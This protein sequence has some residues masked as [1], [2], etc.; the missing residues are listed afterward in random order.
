MNIAAAP[1]SDAAALLA[2]VAERVRSA[3]AARDLPRRAL[4]EMS[5]VS[6]RYLAQLEAGEGNISIALLNRV[7]DALG[8]P[9]DA[10]IAE[11]PPLPAD[12]MR[13][14]QLYNAAP[15]DVKGRVRALLA[16]Q[17]PAAL[18]AQRICLVGLRGAGKSTLGA[19]AAQALGL[20]FIELNKQVEARTG[21]PL[22]EVM[23]LYG[24]DGFRDLEADLLED[25]IAQNDRAIIA[26]GGGIVGTPSTYKRLLERC[27]TIWIR[28]SPAEHMA[29][30]RAQGDMRPMAGNPAAM[31]QLKALLEARSPMY[32]RALVQVDTAG[33]PVNSSVNDVL[34][35][36][37]KHR[38]L[39]GPTT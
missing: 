5:G 6:P 8:L 20:P 4:A 18:R 32:E 36:I 21:M 13:V 29:R 19:A 25:V 35:Q 39:E 15:S 9:I 27:H 1:V 34:A 14:A 17:T 24:Q 7:A 12:V 11:R 2:R 30:V 10:L 28:T 37:A 16:P 38:F 31:E 33:K 23:A 26:V 22:S 3:R